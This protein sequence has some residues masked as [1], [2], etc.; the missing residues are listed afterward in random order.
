L[1]REISVT[2]FARICAQ[3][4]HCASVNIFV[5]PE[6]TENNKYRLLLNASQPLSLIQGFLEVANK[7]MFQP[8]EVEPP[9]IT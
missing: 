7:E 9:K 2:R 5:V 1:Q 8:V 3:D 4:H 6:L